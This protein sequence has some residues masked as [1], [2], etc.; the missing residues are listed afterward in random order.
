MQIINY[1]YINIMKKIFSIAAA[2]AMIFGAASC[3]KEILQNGKEGDSKVVFNVE[4]PEAAVTKAEMSDG[5]TVNELVWEVYVGDKRM[6]Y[7]REKGSKQFV[8][9]LNLVTGQTYDLLFWA[10]TENNNYYDVDDL[11]EVNVSYEGPANDETRDAFYA[12]RLG[13]QATGI[14]TSET[15]KLYRPF[16]QINFGSA[17]NDWDKAQ[18][19]ITKD[20]NGNGGLKSTVTMKDVYTQFNV[21]EGDVVA[22]SKTDIKTFTYD[23]CPASETMYT[24]DYL[25]YKDANGNEIKYGWVAM[26]YVLAPKSEGAMSEVV[27][28][29][30]HN[31]NDASSALV[32]EVINVPFKQNYRTNILGEIFTGGNK[33]TVVIEPGFANTPIED[34]PDYTLAEPVMFALQNGGSVTLNADTPIPSNIRTD[35]DVVINLNGK[36]LEYNAYNGESESL[37][38]AR[39]NKGGSLTINGPGKIVSNGYV[40]SA[41]EGSKIVVNGDVEIEAFT[42]AFQSNGGEVYL[43][44]GTYSEINNEPTYLVNFI[45]AM[46]S[47]GTISIAGGTYHGFN[48]GDNLAEGKGTNFLAPGYT[49]QETSV[50]SGIWTV[51][52]AAPSVVTLNADVKTAATIKAISLVGDNKT[53]TADFSATTSQYIVHAQGSGKIENVKIY[54]SNLRN[55]NDKVQRGIYLSNITDNVEINNVE[56]YDVAYP[57]NTGGKIA[58]GKTLT[59]T[60]SV[61]EGWTSPASFAEVKFTKCTFLAGTYYNDHTNADP[62]W[63]ACFRAATETVLTECTFD[64]G[65]YISLAT[66]VDGKKLTL[67]SCKVKIDDNTTVDL[68]KDNIAAYLNEAETGTLAKVIV[69]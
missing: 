13:F 68:T 51:K 62:S 39:I 52:A 10:Q 23:L 2:F 33:F 44:G 37:I 22:S 7:G 38:M 64:K 16:A 1:K 65:F 30:V 54:G 40:A 11:R 49:A 18:P 5:S 24:N 6:Y 34:F 66:M 55:V 69:K 9:E 45:D 32:K 42:T 61:F 8:L 56:V 28:S 31:M 14:A 48:P 3:Q 4:I 63:N 58:S 25:V 26:N 43:L 53:I 20:E 36:T 67:D 59:V 19:F 21:A 29:F 15:I 50:G 41:N 46:R 57:L 12:A 27:A 17:P 47:V 60:N 35:K